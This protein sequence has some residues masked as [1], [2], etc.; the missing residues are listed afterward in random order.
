MLGVHPCGDL[1]CITALIA[2][3]GI[4]LHL[5]GGIHHTEALWDDIQSDKVVRGTIPPDRRDSHSSWLLSL[6]GHCVNASFFNTS[7]LEVEKLEPQQ[8]KL[9]ENIREC[10]EKAG[11]T[12]YR[13]KLV[14]SFV[15]TFGD[16]W[17]LSQ[18]NDD[19]FACGY[20]LEGAL[21][22]ANLVSY[23]IDFQGPSM[24]IKTCCSASLVGL[25][26][27]AGGAEDR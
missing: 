16:D 4:S 21:M 1:L 2:V 13:D 6:G 10:L 3:C 7:K 12:E 24:V 11:K 19:Q 26:V 27:G 17:L 20:S 25:H 23:E 9:I 5:P 8:H 18:T 14:G 22:A 15:G